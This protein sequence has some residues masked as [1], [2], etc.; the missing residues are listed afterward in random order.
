MKAIIPAAGFGTRFLPV[1]KAQPKEMLP[2]LD[3]PIIQYVVEEAHKAGVEELLFV[4]GRAK[5]AIEDHFDTSAELESFLEDR[6]K[7]K[8]LESVRLASQFDNIYYVRQRRPLGLGHAISCGAAFVR[9]EPFFILL[10]DV[11]VPD[12]NVLDSLRKVYEETGASVIAVEEVPTEKIS[13]YGIVGGTSVSEGE[14][15]HLDDHAVYKIDTLVEKPSPEEA[16]SNLA[17]FGRYLLSPRAMEFIAQTKPGRGGEIQLTDA[18]VELAKVEPIYAVTVKP[19]S[20]FDTGNVVSWL[21]ANATLAIRH[22]KYGE[23]AREML[24]DILQAAKREEA[25]E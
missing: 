7:H 10:G 14:A 11:I 3:K 15:G 13:S 22:E 5:R 21:H 8:E 9:D 19:Q 12:C 25:S 6:G 18:L 2:V 24:F 20:G 1:T 17:I 4:T 23:A 16:P